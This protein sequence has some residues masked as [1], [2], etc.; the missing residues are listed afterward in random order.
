MTPLVTKPVGNNW[1]HLCVDAQRMFLDATDWHIPWFAKTIPQMAALAA[2]APARTVF[3]RFIP[4]QSKGEGHGLW[5]EYYTRWES[6]TLDSIGRQAVEVVD[7][8]KPF[9]PPAR[10]IDKHVYSPWLDTGLHQSLQKDSIDTLIVSGGETDVCVL[11]TVIGAVDYGYR[12]ILA[13]DAVCG[14]CDDT[15]DKAKALFEERFNTQVEAAT[16]E[17]ILYLLPKG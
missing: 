7:E 6:M 16:V 11:A 13:T 3:T 12:I 2:V 1:I 5:R 10:V 4:A 17:E 8:L 15:H 14:S 9:I